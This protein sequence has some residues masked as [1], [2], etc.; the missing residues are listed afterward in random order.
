MN[1]PSLADSRT[2]KLHQNH[3]IIQ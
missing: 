1:F 3:S 2:A